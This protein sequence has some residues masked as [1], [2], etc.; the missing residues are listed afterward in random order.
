[1]EDESILIGYL[2][3]ITEKVK[4]L[5]DRHERYSDSHHL[6]AF[7]GESRDYGKT[8]LMPSLF[9]EREYVLKEKYLFEL[10]GDYGFLDSQISRN[11]DRAIEAQHYIAISRMLDISFSVLP[12]LYF[13]CSSNNK[14]DGRLYIFCFPEHY[15]P[16]SEYIEEFY[17]KVFKEDNI[18]YSSNF[19]VI[20][21]SFSNERIKA[22]VGGFIF[23][24]GMEYKRINSIYYEAVDIKAC[25]K[26]DILEE[27]EIL[28]HI[29]K[30][31][32]FPEKEELALVIKDKFV[33]G[34]YH[35]KKITVE[36]EVE[37]YF[38]RVEYELAMMIRGDKESIPDK[39]TILRYL[40]KEEDDLLRYILNN[41]D[42]LKESKTLVQETKDMFTYLQ[43][44][45]A[46]EIE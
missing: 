42:K 44:K 33:H 34:D 3:K 8:S 9:R 23:F 17:S 21:H 43:M 7:R 6:L 10:L 13:A 28:F 26:K 22:Q 39:I 46:G 27:L 14:L 38:E 11:V 32:L 45:Y 5:C 16:H 24:P 31:S 1:M 36:K 30:A 25:D 19:K 20:S 35:N 15:S 4:S 2:K 37:A 12:A 40:R 29:S 41:E 18:T